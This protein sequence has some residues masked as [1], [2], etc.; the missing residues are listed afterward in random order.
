MLKKKW[1]KNVSGATNVG[2]IVLSL[3]VR[4]YRS[5]DQTGSRNMK[6]TG[7][8]LHQYRSFLGSITP[9][10]AVS[11]GHNGTDCL[12]GSGH[13]SLFPVMKR[14]RVDVV[15]AAQFCRAY[16]G[17]DRFQH[18]LDLLLWCK[19]ALYHG[20]CPPILRLM[21][22]DAG[23]LLLEGSPPVFILIDKTVQL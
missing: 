2:R 9:T 19:F 16:A 17:S 8:D 22:M 12:E 23:V 15:L 7:R 6:W 1:V 10:M 14:L 13:E 20:I 18:N 21:C 4:R 5:I 11:T 3:Y